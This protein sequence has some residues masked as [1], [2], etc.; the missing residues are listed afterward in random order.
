[1]WQL[2]EI[3]LNLLKVFI[4]IIINSIINYSKGGGYC[5]QEK[6]KLRQQ[7]TKLFIKIIN[8]IVD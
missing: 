5:I 7:K 1:M 3:K 4:S 8:I 2:L 6:I